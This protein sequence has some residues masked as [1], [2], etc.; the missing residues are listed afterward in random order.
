MIVALD[1]ETT[2]LELENDAIIEVAL[3]KFDEKTW[4]VLDTFSSFVNPLFP[5]PD[6]SKSI[7]W[8]TD[9]DVE[10]APCIE[11]LIDKIE[12]FIWDSPILWHN[13]KFDYDFLTYAW[14]KIEKNIVL[15]TFNLANFLMFEEKTLSLEVI[16]KKLW[17]TQSNAH[18]A[19][20]DTLA[21]KDLFI[22]LISQIKKLPN[23]KKDIIGYFF[24]NYRDKWLDFL[25]D[26]TQISKTDF[27]EFVWI[28]NK[29][30][31]NY[32]PFELFEDSDAF[33]DEKDYSAFNI[34]KFLWSDKNF[35]KRENQT[36]MWNIVWKTLKNAEKTMIEAPTWV[37][38]TFAYLLPSI[39]YSIKNN[40]RVFISTNTKALQDQIFYKD[41]AFFADKLWLDFSY[42]KLKWKSNYVWVTSFLDFASWANID[43][44]YWVF[45]SLKVSFW[46]LETQF[47]ELDELNYY[48]FEY[49]YKKH[50]TADNYI[51]LSDENELKKKEFVYKARQNAM[52]SNI[53]IINHS[54]LVQNSKSWW[55]IFWEI[56]NLVLDEAHNLENT[57]TDALKTQVDSVFLSWILDEIEKILHKEKVSIWNFSSFREDI[58]LN[59]SWV[60]NISYDFL[61]AN[62]DWIN[63]RNYTNW[64]ID[65][66]FYDFVW[67]W[68]SWVVW[69]FALSIS[70][71][72]E[73]LNTLD[74]E[75]FLK[76]SWVIEKLEEIL[77]IASVLKDSSEDNDNIKLISYSDRFWVSLWYTKLNIWTYLSNNIWSKL[78]SVV[79]TSATLKVYDSFDYISLVLGLEDF[80]FESFDSDFDY[81]KQALV[82]VP[83]N[84]WSIKNNSE[85][86]KIF[87]KDFFNI[88]SWKT[89]A[90][91]TSFASIKELYLDLKPELK[92]KDI[93]LFAQSIWW[94]KH[95][96]LELF[97]ENS[98]NSVLFW[99]DT[100]WEW[101]DIPWDDLEFLIVHKF[102]FDVPV[103]PIFIARSKLY[104]R[105]FNEYAIP[106]AIIKL[107][108]W[109]WRLIRTKNDKWIVILLDDRIYSSNWWEA[110]YGAFPK[111]VKV[112]TW[113]YEN[114]LS[115][116][117]NKIKQEK[118]K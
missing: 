73:V 47:W 13:V 26:L 44:L 94:W 10:K 59:F 93:N 64:L 4:E 76:V 109:F 110:F 79:L 27:D 69:D 50:I 98:K 60:C 54:L 57:L 1:L 11:D 102:P 20:D 75:I 46:L 63:Q 78:D 81:E 19:L 2:W 29:K 86:I 41:L 15:D 7:T 51:T 91:F 96:L 56:K 71:L 12:D 18:R 22:N 3:V 25:L 108:Q 95:K 103:D 32:K 21:T 74:D 85:S 52:N 88:V 97:K 34:E 58:T 107:K 43:D 84:L 89:L 35:E 8:I 106:K 92:T 68:F 82:F 61:S 37:W 36:N 9:E 5:I 16:S 72:V 105:S 66:K 40:E 90:L 23:Y 31:K 17:I 49:Q 113:P 115:S 24:W 45:F 111:G 101:I 33:D 53:V 6:I 55:A 87:F 118:N 62:Y 112:K 99:T 30:I 117:E 38:K 28:I 116:L 80:N 48:P 77:S 39:K 70:K 83:N 114:F 14:C 100:F 42:C 104:K 65:S 67:E